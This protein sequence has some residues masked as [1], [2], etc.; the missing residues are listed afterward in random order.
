MKKNIL[1]I[2]ITLVFSLFVSNAITTPSAIIAI[3]I[4]IIISTQKR[5]NKFPL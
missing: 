4:I 3:T 1:N 2:L 5:R